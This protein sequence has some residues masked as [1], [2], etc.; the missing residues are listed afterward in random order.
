MDIVQEDNRARDV[1]LRLRGLLRKGDSKPEPVDLNKLVDSTITLLRREL[2]R[3]QIMAETN[4][5]PSL[6][7]VFADPVQLRQVLLNLILNAMD[8]MAATPLAHR[9]IRISTRATPA[10][11]VETSVKDNGPGIESLDGSQPFEP[12]YKGARPWSWSIHLLDNLGQARR[13]DHF[14]K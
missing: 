6:P 9:Q 14:T 12:F 11:T 10:A 8:A 3:R 1:I 13:I 5:T 4:L 7:I 2:I